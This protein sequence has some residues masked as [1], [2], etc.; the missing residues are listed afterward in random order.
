MSQ[1]SLNFQWPLLTF[2]RVTNIFHSD[3]G[4]QTTKN[5]V[6]HMNVKTFR[7]ICVISPDQVL[8]AVRQILFFGGFHGNL[9]FLVNNLVKMRNS[10]EKKLVWK[11][12]DITSKM[13]RRHLYETG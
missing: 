9:L 6:I 10:S 4:G 8:I 12:H 1:K 5:L 7:N 2:I 13:D 11:K 3:A